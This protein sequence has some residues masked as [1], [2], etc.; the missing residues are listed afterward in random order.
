MVAHPNAY[1]S[2]SGLTCSEK[3]MVTHCDQRTRDLAA[4]V[5][6]RGLPSFLVNFI[7]TVRHN[8]TQAWRGAHFT[9]N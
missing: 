1:A 8:I 3:K 5:K 4:G 2:A 7:D 6:L 9:F